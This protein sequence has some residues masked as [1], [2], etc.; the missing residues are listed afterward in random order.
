MKSSN[1]IPL[2]HSLLL[3]LTLHSL[4]ETK[5]VAGKKKSCLGNDVHVL[6]REGL[7]FRLC[8]P[9]VN[10]GSLNGVLIGADK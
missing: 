4:I 5:E 7:G 3:V 1:T 6:C 10:R 8:F 9:F 2:P